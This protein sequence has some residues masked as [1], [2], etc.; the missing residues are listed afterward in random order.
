[1]NRLGIWINGFIYFRKIITLN[2]F[3]KIGFGK[4]FFR[5]VTKATFIW[6]KIQYKHIV[7]YYKNELF[8]CFNIIFK[9]NVFLGGK[10]E[11]LGAITLIFSVTLQK[12]F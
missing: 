11:F 7:K 5:D 1:M 12:S 6:A 8:L 2:S 3:Q 10:A 4:I 9:C